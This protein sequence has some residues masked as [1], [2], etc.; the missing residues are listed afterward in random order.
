MLS[1]E[2]RLVFQN[3]LIPNEYK[4]ET[5]VLALT[6]GSIYMGDAINVHLKEKKKQKKNKNELYIPHGYGTAF[7]NKSGRKYEGLWYKGY[8]HGKGKLFFG[9]NKEN[10][11]KYIGNFNMDQSDG[12]GELE[13]SNGDIIIGKWKNGILY[14]G[15]IISKD[16][17]E[18]NGSI[19]DYKKHGSGSIIYNNKTKHIGYWING[20][21]S[22][23]GLTILSNGIKMI[24]MWKNDKP[25]G[26]MKLIF[27]PDHECEEYIGFCNKNTE[28]HGKGVMKYKN[29]YQYHGEWKNN[30]KNGNG[31]M[32]D[33]IGNYYSGTWENDMRH[34]NGYFYY[35]FNEI[36]KYYKWE[37]DNVV[38]EY[39]AN[40]LYLLAKT[41]NYIY[42][43]SSVKISDISALQ[44]LYC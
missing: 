24:G 17:F 21:R 41:T 36:A 13:F 22:G 11:V 23:K 15:K 3:L 44:I 7:N 27:P 4:I 19:K 9:I 30:A 32:K 26:S 16:N 29:D 38:F 33:N 12:D 31:I 39:D 6:D 40:D 14:T 43:N 35:K 28:P 42:R 10:I 37:N 20:M 25:C 8:A 18:Y 2:T 1:Q 34:G 5:K